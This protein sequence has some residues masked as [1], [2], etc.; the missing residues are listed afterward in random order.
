RGDT[1]KRQEG[2]ALGGEL[3]VHHARALFAVQII[4]RA[5]E[6]LEVVE[7]HHADRRDAAA[8]DEDIAPF[9]DAGGVRDARR[10]RRERER[11]R[12]E[13]ESSRGARGAVRDRVARERGER[14]FDVQRRELLARAG[15]GRFEERKGAEGARRALGIDLATE[16]RDGLTSVAPPALLVARP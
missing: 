8:R 3:A 2:A 15:G 16:A 12:R 1:A 6:E 9:E 14:A 13:P 10:D 5:R 7:P 11:E 4:G